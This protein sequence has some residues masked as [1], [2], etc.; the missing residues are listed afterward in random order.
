MTVCEH[1][2]QNTLA[3]EVNFQLHECCMHFTNQINPTFIIHCWF[4]YLFS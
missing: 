1:V 2:S 3:S 4:T